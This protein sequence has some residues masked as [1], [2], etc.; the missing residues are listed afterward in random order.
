MIC[1]AIH[2]QVLSLGKQMTMKSAAVVQLLGT[3]REGLGPKFAKIQRPFESGP[4][5]DVLLEARPMWASVA[6]GPDLASM[7]RLDQF[8]ARVKTNPRKRR[9]RGHGVFGG[10]YP[11]ELGCAVEGWKR[12]RSMSSVETSSDAAIIDPLAETS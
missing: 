7:E 1:D 6:S 12:R 3:L 9:A 2:S 4:A 11:P 5:N 8:L 10:R